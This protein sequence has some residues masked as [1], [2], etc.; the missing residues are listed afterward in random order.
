MEPFVDIHVKKKC[1][2]II[3]FSYLF[4]STL[5]VSSVASAKRTTHFFMT[6]DE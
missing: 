1:I 2:Q 5:E 3:L 4:E 6:S